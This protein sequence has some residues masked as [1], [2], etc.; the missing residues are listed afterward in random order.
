MVESGLK[1]GRFTYITIFP[2]VTFKTKYMI[3]YIIKLHHKANDLSFR[4]NSL[5]IKV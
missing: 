5:N 2:I 3:V 4:T 1:E